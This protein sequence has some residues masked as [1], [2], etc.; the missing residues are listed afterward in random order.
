MARYIQNYER[1]CQGANTCPNMCSFVGVRIWFGAKIPM[2]FKM[3]SVWA[4]QTV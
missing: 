4:H 3:P 1:I 2:F